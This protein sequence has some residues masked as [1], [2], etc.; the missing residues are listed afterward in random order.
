MT[1]V[2]KLRALVSAIKDKAPQGFRGNLA[3]KALC[4][5]LTLNLAPLIVGRS[6]ALAGSSNESR[7][8]VAVDFVNRERN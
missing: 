8:R 3:G 6:L 2:G 5:K 1:S 7:N 4:E